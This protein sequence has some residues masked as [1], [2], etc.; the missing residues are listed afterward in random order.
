MSFTFCEHCTKGDV[1]PG[2]PKGSMQDGAYFAPGAD[3]TKAVML[4]TDIFGLPLVN[5]KI[6]ADQLA[7]QVGCDVW[8]PDQFN[9]SPPFAP[10]ELDG[11]IPHTPGT[12]MAFSSK[13]Y[14]FWNILKHL[15][16]LI[17]N[18]PSV[19]DTRIQ[20]FTKQ[21]KEKKGYAKIGIVGYCWGGAT[22]IR[23]ASTGLI[24][25]AVI[26]H[27]GRCNAEQI[28]A[29]K[30]PTSWLCAEEDPSFGP[31]L[32]AEAEAIFAARKDKP[33]FLA[34]EFHEYK[35]TVH[36]FAARPELSVPEIKEGFEKA[37][38]ATIKWFKQT[39]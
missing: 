37:F 6:M 15:P 9:G 26:V 39:L 33:D 7:E 1:L 13:L 16:N 3:K 25:T 12:K 4:L 32:R 20:T 38:E 28:R 8:V 10:S 2:K 29:M 19:T 24:D 11:V 17:S 21:L 5:C 30:T 23:L 18:R 36:G 35:G 34:Y 22:G 31:E 14:L 27:P